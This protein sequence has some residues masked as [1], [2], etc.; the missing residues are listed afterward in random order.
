MK[1]FDVTG[2]TINGAALVHETIKFYDDLC[3]NYAWVA[4]TYGISGNN[5]GEV[6]PV[7][8]RRVI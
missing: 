2:Q 7:G 5:A 6:T 3:P 8:E 1:D 4:P